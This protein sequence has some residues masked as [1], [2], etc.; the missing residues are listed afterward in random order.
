MLITF[1]CEN[2]GS[3]LEVEAKAAGTEAKCPQCRAVFSVPHKGPGPGATVGGFYIE[4]LLGKGGMGEVYRARQLSMDREVAVKILPAR[5]TADKELVQEFLHEVRMAARLQ[6]PNIVTAYE[7][8][9][10]EGAYFMAMEY[11]KGETLAARLASEGPLPEKTALT[12]VQKLAVALAYAWDEHQ[13]LHRD[14]KP[15]NVMVNSRGDP[16]LTDMGVSKSISEST[17]VTEPGTIMGTPNYMSPE[18]A[19]GVADLDCRTDMYALGATLHHMLTGN[20]PFAAPTFTETLRQQATQTLPD[21]RTIA[22]TVSE[23][24]SHLLA[25][26]LARKPDDRHASWNDLL[27]DIKRVLAQKQPE[28]AAPPP[29]STVLAYVPADGPKVTHIR[30]SHDEAHKLHAR[31]A[32]RPRREQTMLPVLLI[33]ILVAA[34]LGGGLYW[35]TKHRQRVA[36]EAHARELSALCDKAVTFAQTHPDDYT[37]AIGQLNRVARIAAGTVWATKARQEI[38]RVKTDR[39]MGIRDAVKALEEETGA[40]VKQG[41]YAD[42]LARL[43][44]YDGPFARE[45]AARRKALAEDVQKAKAEAEA[46]TARRAAEAA[47]NRPPPPYDFA[48]LLTTVADALVGGNAAAANAAIEAARAAI[49]RQQDREELAKVVAVA[50][51]PARI[52][53]FLLE[54][55]RKDVGNDI[56][57]EFIGGRENLRVL[58]VT[59]TG[60]DAEAAIVTGGH[61]RAAKSRPFAIGELGVGERFRRLTDVPMPTRDMLRGFLAVEAKHFD[62]AQRYFDAVDSPVCKA[63]AA[64]CGRQAADGNAAAVGDGN[65]TPADDGQ[66]EAAA[67]RAYRMLLVAAGLNTSETRTDAQLEQLE[68][69]Q[70]SLQ[71]RQD[72]GARTAALRSD[73][74]DTALVRANARV[75]DALAAAA[76]GS[77]HIDRPKLYEAVDRLRRDNP[78]MDKEPTVRVDDDGAVVDIDGQPMLKD[79]SALAGLPIKSLNISGSRIEDLRA[80]K[81]MPLQELDLKGCTLIDDILPLKGLP[82]RVLDIREC[83]QVKDITALK[84]MLLRTLRLF[85]CGIRDV[86][87][88]RGMPLETLELTYCVDVSDLGPLRDAPL[89]NLNINSTSVADLRPLKGAPLSSLDLRGC[90]FITDLGPLAGMPLKELNL[91]N[92]S[93][94]KDLRPLKGMPLEKLWLQ[95][96]EVTDI[97]P[98]RGM[99]LVLLDARET[100]IEDFG[101]VKDITTLKDLLR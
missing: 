63:L 74:G 38:V 25:T 100:E 1:P 62:G 69:R 65:N 24:C 60:I 40:A 99:P 84:G 71:R 8:G 21:P 45:T 39:E 79:I 6:H 12:I 14:V 83:T 26:M 91:I 87:A 75:L 55:F 35:F 27:H 31:A 36:M 42:A 44:A 43:T 81:G 17:V 37:E 7:A 16:R 82:L 30:I 66:R 48:P 96:T 57:V 28:Y 80:L 50:G 53:D 73:Y 9:E 98:L 19:D 70:F 22:P 86:K 23:A 49:T 18:Q 77:V 101:P 5:L 78:G 51:I 32:A 20:I 89:T 93:A 64:A 85:R 90:R 11:V 2:C 94:I 92:C 34:A 52:D 67:A 3:Q 46:E 72:I 58:K 59:P 54:T 56:T 15:E 97:S 76:G 61:T 88:L 41:E 47:R 33:I 95:H 10:D 29:G 13:M 68:R 4:E